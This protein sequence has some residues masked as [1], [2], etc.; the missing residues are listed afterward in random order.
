MRQLPQYLPRGRRAP[1]RGLIDSAGAPFP[2]GKHGMPA[3]QPTCRARLSAA[4]FLSFFR[5]AARRRR[6]RPT[7]TN[8]RSN[9]YKAG[10]SEQGFPA[11]NDYATGPRPNPPSTKR[12]ARAP[13]G[14]EL[15]RA[16]RPVGYPYP[17]RCGAVCRCQCPERL[18]QRPPAAECRRARP[19][20]NPHKL[21]NRPA[22]A[23]RP[24]RPHAGPTRNR[25]AQGRVP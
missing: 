15:R 19:R 3:P 18:R 5:Q 8:R 14:P 9:K 4:G 25:R 20:L 17:N 11:P 10:G 16:G 12:P 6:F 22:G 24:G 2:P 7:G 13:P 23:L 21:P 1:Q